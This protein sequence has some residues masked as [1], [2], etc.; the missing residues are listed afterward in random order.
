MR[1]PEEEKTSE[2]DSTLYERVARNITQLIDNGTLRAGERIPSVRQIHTHQQVSI[3][4]AVQA[5][6]LLE[7]RGIIEARP[8]SG[9]YVRPKQWVQPP[10]P[11]MS[12]PAL[13]ATKVRVSDLVME[14][15]QSTRDP[16]LIRLGATLPSPELFP[17]LEL[18]RTMGA[19]GR[20]NPHLANCYDAPPGHKPL[21]VQIARRAIEA[22]CALSPDEIV[23]TCGATEAL[24]LCL[25]AV[26]KPGDTIAIESPTFF[27]FLQIIEALGM[28]ACEIPTFPREGVC[29][30]ELKSRL[31][32]CRIKACLFALN[33]SNPLGSCMPDA[34]KKALVEL[35]AE[36]NVPLIEDDLSGNLAHDLQRPKAAKSF[37]KHGMVLLVDSFTKTLAPGF[38]VGWAVAGKF[39]DRVQLLK[40]TSTS[41]TATLP[42]MAIADYLANTSYDHHLRRVRRFYAAQT[43]KVTEAL[44]HS[45]PEGTRVS[46]P[47]GGQVLWVELPSS[48]SAIELYR[49]ALINKISIAPGPIFSPT[50]RFL[51]C[52][53]INV[54]NTWNHAVESAIMRLGVLAREL[55]DAQPAGSA[56]R[57]QTSS[58][59]QRPN[60]NRAL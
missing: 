57:R 11:E 33:F 25:R 26:A 58:R 40:F 45:F 9:Y 39:V 15:I 21:R 35:L 54:G 50:Q 14:V 23:I 13:K 51:N 20:R 19:A 52:I 28:R 29:L 17:T 31:G 3:S 32:R 36:H 6:R 24:N 22:G 10:E 43:L 27:G 53:R 38:R 34:R 5:Y 2:A 49:Q 18:N 41:A 44:S 37:D 7:T 1:I 46:R 59:P 12:R 60:L 4:T 8:Q 56:L 16:S 48:L 42:Q 47:R 30:D 55:R